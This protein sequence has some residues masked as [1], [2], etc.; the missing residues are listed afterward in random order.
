MHIDELLRLMIPADASDLHFKAGRPPLFRVDGDLKPVPEF[1]PVSH[2]Q[3]VELLRPVL[4]P[5]AVRRFAERREADCAYEVAGAARFRVNVFQQRGA[6]GAVLRL[7]PADVPT[8]EE[9]GLPEVLNEF[10][11]RENGLVLVTGPT[12]SGKSTTLAAMVERINR[13]RPLH[14]VTI[15]DPVEFVYV[16]KTATI[17]Q[18]E[19]GTDTESLADALRAVLRQDP[20]I[21]LMGEMRDPETV[22]FGITAAETG[23]LVFAT[24]HTNDAPQT[25]ERIMDILPET[26]QAVARQQLSI[27]LRA[28]VCQRLLKRKNGH[29]RVPALEIMAVNETVRQLIAENKM[30]AVH[31]AMEEGGYYRMQTFNQALY[32]LAESGQVDAEEAV[33]ASDAPEDLRLRF[34]GIRR[35]SGAEETMKQMAREAA[36]QRKSLHDRIQ[37]F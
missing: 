18:R 10:A 4:P 22:K 17:N 8:I 30:R 33:A 31:K 24:L 25:L 7:I 12:G 29:G 15:E 28:I 13:T 1:P 23:H 9:L 2:E 14:V 27:L 16:D 34:R 26:A 21:I 3:I 36:D 6:V 20:D 11:D 19:L 35:G 32:A 5:H 37:R